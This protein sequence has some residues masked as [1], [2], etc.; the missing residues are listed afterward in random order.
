LRYATGKNETNVKIHAERP[1][2]ND[3]FLYIVG[4]FDMF[5]RRKK[6]E[7]KQFC[8]YIGD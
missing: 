1:S 2:T 6:G 8:E 4:T 7:G 3:A 5:T